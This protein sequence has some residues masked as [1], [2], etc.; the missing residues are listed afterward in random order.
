[1]QTIADTI[2]QLP[3][4]INNCVTGPIQKTSAGTPN[5]DVT[6]EVQSNGQIVAVPYPNCIASGNAAPCWSSSPGIGS[7]TGQSFAVT[8]APGAPSLVLN[9][10]C[11]LCQA[12]VTAPG[13]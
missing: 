3:G 2:V 13:C 10:T 6:A 9:V 7:C 8:D 11:S 12:G 1:M 5:C 4:A